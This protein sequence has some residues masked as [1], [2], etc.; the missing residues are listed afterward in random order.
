MFGST[1]LDGVALL[2]LYMLVLGVWLS[3]VEYERNRCRLL[4][5]PRAD[6]ITEI[7]ELEPRLHLHNPL[8]E[9][10]R[11]TLSSQMDTMYAKIA[12]SC[13]PGI[14]LGGDSNNT[15]SGYEGTLW[16]TKTWLALGSLT[17]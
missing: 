8:L 17:R 16:R 14:G 3:S 15:D 4:L 13:L 1:M 7:T 9:L 11:A 12:E 10:M 2:D 6:H 5:S